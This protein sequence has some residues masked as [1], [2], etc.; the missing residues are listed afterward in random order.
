MKKDIKQE[1]IKEIQRIYKEQG[2]ISSPLFERH[3]KFS[4]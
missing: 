1:I 3:S 2:K 4:M